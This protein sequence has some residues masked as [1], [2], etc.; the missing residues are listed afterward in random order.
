MDYSCRITGREIQATIEDCPALISGARSVQLLMMSDSLSSIATERATTL[1]KNDVKIAVVGAGAIGGITAAFLAKAGW[2]VELVCK[3]ADAARKA[4]SEGLHIFGICPE[5]RVRVNAVARTGDLSGPKDLVFIATKA[6]D[7]VPAAREALPFLKPESAVVSLQNGICEEALEEVVGPDRTFGCVVAWGATMGSPGEMEKTSDGEFVIGRIDSAPDPRLTLIQGALND[8]A[9]TRISD[10]IM[11]ELYSKLIINSCINTLGVVAGLPLG[12]LLAI[13]KVRNIFFGLMCE[14]MAVAQAMGIKVAAGGG[15]KLDYYDFLKGSGYLS[16]LR[17]HLIVR[18]VG[19][20][21]RRIR[22]S[23]LQSL[24]RGRK[25]EIDYLNGYICQKGR[26]HGVPTGL[27][28][29]LVTM[30]KEIESG[31]RPISAD[32]LNHPAFDDF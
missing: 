10:N 27:H 6:Y 11:G 2:D 9:P 22:S 1:E 17:R 31:Q 4:A 19:F 29:A 20:K 12:R 24:E 5:E 13:K 32:N 7:C 30:V 25:T 15:G 8:A 18:I 28:D 26:Q 23:S 14:A 16:R 3:H 21:Y